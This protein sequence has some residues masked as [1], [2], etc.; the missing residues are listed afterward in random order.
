M[1]KPFIVSWE[2]FWYFFFS[3]IIGLVLYYLLLAF[4]EGKGFSLKTRTVE[5]ILAGVLALVL[6]LLLRW[7]FG[8]YAIGII[9]GLGL[10]KYFIPTLTRMFTNTAAR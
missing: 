3:I 5:L 9:I 1:F 4:K 7:S 8:L 10:L 2:I 6:S